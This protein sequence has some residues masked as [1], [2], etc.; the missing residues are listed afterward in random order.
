[1]RMLSIVMA[2]FVLVSLPLQAQADEKEVLDDI[3]KFYHEFESSLNTYELEKAADVLWEYT[4]DDF[5]RKIDGEV[6]HTR[7]SLYEDTKN[8]KFENGHSRA[9]FEFEDMSYDPEKKEAVLVFEASTYSSIDGSTNNEM[10]TAVR[11]HDYF[12]VNEEEKSYKMYLCDCV[13]TV[14]PNLP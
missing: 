8:S 5:V 7:Q 14:R 13:Y 9:K 12:R 6:M 4:A 1:M 10:R 2:L 3:L 11:C